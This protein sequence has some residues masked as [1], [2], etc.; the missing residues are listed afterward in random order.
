L[1][2]RRLFRGE[3]DV[4]TIANV[5]RLRVE[6][7]SRDNERV[8]VELDEICLRALHRDPNARF[9]DCAAM[10]DRL[11]M[12][13]AALHWGAEQTASLLGSL[14]PAR[15]DDGRLVLALPSTD[16]GTVAQSGRAR[17]S[18]GRRARIGVALG[19]T[20]ALT[21]TGWALRQY[22]ALEPP[23]NTTTVI[24]A[25]TVVVAPPERAPELP[26][27]PETAPAAIPPPSAPTPER[28]PA[29][30]VKRGRVKAPAPKPAKIPAKAIRKGEVVD[31]FSP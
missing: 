9:P 16:G 15:T 24:P 14:F 30:H 6:P 26:S 18:G 28:H 5:R 2:G 7:P 27:P 10:A 29:R 3:S 12:T 23:P 4:Q 17:R 8:P 1:S 11:E 22:I 21:A 19:V 20:A 13:A 31:P 25:P